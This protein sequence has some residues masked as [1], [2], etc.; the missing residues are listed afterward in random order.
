M[1]R[2]QTKEGSGGEESCVTDLIQ[3]CP[4][5]VVIKTSLSVACVTDVN[6]VR[7]VPPLVAS[8]QAELSPL[9]LCAPLVCIVSL[10]ETCPCGPARVVWL[11]LLLGA[12]L[13]KHM[14][15]HRC[16]HATSCSTSKQEMHLTC[17]CGAGGDCPFIFLCLNLFLSSVILL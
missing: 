12:C 13:Y 2:T 17:V 4:R 16:S 1:F 14:R 6:F 7:T 11:H 5:L 10:L 15:E 9:L 8:T 3:H